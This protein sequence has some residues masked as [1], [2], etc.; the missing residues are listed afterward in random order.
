MYCVKYI[1]GQVGAASELRG[2][3][4]SVISNKAVALSVSTGS[5]L[6]APRCFQLPSLAHS[7]VLRDAAELVDVSL[8]GQ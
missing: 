7:C 2:I 5:S 1:I 4:R 3:Q 8:H 6:S